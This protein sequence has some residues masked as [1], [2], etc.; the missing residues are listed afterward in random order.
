MSIR[1]LNADPNSSYFGIGRS[2]TLTR[3]YIIGAAKHGQESRLSNTMLVSVTNV[4]P[5]PSFFA[6]IFHVRKPS[7]LALPSAEHRLVVHLSRY[8]Q[9][10]AQPVPLCGPGLARLWSLRSLVWTGYVHTL[11]GDSRLVE[12]FIQAL[13]LRDITWFGQDITGS[14]GL[15]WGGSTSRM[16]PS[17]STTDSDHSYR[18]Q[19]GE[20]YTRLTWTYSA[21]RR[22]FVLVTLFPGDAGLSGQG[23]HGIHDDRQRRAA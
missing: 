15:G 3:G 1:T 11:I 12:R 20:T 10:A 2:I 23:D 7:H 18:C 22:L 5:R 21:D 4:P 14:A 8:H 17:G 6:M 13:G 19:P 16:V 9:G